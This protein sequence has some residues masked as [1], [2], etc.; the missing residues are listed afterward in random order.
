MSFA[1]PRGRTAE[2]GGPVGARQAGAGANRPASGVWVSSDGGGGPA[3]L[4][5]D[6]AARVPGGDPLDVL[7]Y[8]DSKTYLPGDILTKVDRMSM[9]V[10]LE[11][12]VP[13]LDHKL[14]EFAARL[15][16]GLKM[17][18]GESKYVFKRAV[19]GLVP[20]EILDRPK[21]GFGVPITEWINLELRER[22]RDTF[23]DARTRRRGLFE[24]SYV[25]VL[26][27]E[28]ERGRRDHSHAVW[29][30]FVLELWHRAYADEPA[31]A[32]AD[33]VPLLTAVG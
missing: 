8:L 24:P 28:H 3:A 5:R 14:I 1:R 31:G 6:Y 19:R 9:A 12:R 15:P 2:R 27:A 4:F 17:R 10:S 33:N 22:I 25:D 26:L 30:L 16:A 23:A 7:L 13:L 29:S 18:G 20:E 11:A 21:Q 32:G